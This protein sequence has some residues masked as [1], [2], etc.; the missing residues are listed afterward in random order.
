MPTSEA[1]LHQLGRLVRFA[2][3]LVNLVSQLAHVVKEGTSG[4]FL[5]IELS[6]FIFDLG[7]AMTPFMD[8]SI[9]WQSIVATCTC[10][11]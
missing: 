11:E 3:K 1:A 10:K 2:K 4:F 6:Q 5:W 8:Y 9:K 7:M